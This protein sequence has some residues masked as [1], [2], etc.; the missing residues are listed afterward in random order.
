MKGKRREHRYPVKKVAGGAG[1]HPAVVSDKMSLYDY[2]LMNGVFAAFCLLQFGIVRILLPNS[3]GLI[4][5]FGFLIVGFAV[6]S[7]FDYFAAG[8]IEQDTRTIQE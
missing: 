2:V 6:V 3:L 5:F 1:A 4:F 8:A 7:M